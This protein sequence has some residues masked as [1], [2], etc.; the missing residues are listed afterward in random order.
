[1]GH[2]AGDALLIE[3]AARLEASARAGDTVARLGGDEFAILMED[4]G[5]PHE[6]ARRIL[7]LL[8]RPVRLG[9]HAVAVSA[10]IGIATIDGAAREHSAT[11]IL[12]QADLALYAAKRTGK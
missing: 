2:P 3:V 6:L 9:S 5:S 11:E 4:R 10:S 8:R 1:L 7:D 12:H